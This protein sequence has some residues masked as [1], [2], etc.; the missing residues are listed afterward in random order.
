MRDWC[1]FTGANELNPEIVGRGLD[2]VKVKVSSKLN[3]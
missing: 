3:R 1:Y 2:S